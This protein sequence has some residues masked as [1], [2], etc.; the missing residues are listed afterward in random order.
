M[1]DSD[2]V[3]ERFY[4]CPY[5]GNSFVSTRKKLKRVD[6]KSIS[7]SIVCPRCTNNLKTDSGVLSS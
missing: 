4:Y 1:I 3:E 6:M 2:I 7:S 5:C